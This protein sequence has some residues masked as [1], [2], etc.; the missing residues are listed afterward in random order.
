MTSNH[1][2]TYRGCAITTRCIEAHLPTDWADLE[3]LPSAWATRFTASFSVCLNE[4]RDQ[5]WQE[6][7][8][9]RFESCQHATNNALYAARRAI[10]LRLSVI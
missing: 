4:M 10:D 6:F 7:P 8:N 2:S 9:A 3:N 1:S 5:S